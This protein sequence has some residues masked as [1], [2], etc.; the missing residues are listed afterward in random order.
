MRKYLYIFAVFLYILGVNF[1]LSSTHAL[2]GTIE[3]IFYKITS[4]NTQLY[5]VEE[6]NQ[7]TSD[8]VCQL[9]NS[10]FVEPISALDS[11]YLLV[12]YFGVRGAVLLEN[13]TPVYSTPSTPYNLQNFDIVK[14]CDATIWSRPNTESTYLASIPYGTKS[15]SLVGSVAGQ[16]IDSSDTGIW[17]L[18][19]FTSSDSQSITGYVHS[20]ISTNLSAFVEN[21]ETVQLEPT[22][23]ASTTIFAPELSNTNNLLLILLLSIPAVIILLVILR[24]RHSKAR[25]ARRQIKSLNQLSLPDKNNSS[26][27]DF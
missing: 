2:A 27:F 18:C 17:Y 1:M 5:R 25:E 12:T 20:S 7:I 24:P 9:P 19:K 13:L 22:I 15:I 4:E 21:T 14:T 23:T 10:Y 3:P 8:I 16:K 6:S 26:D 11:N